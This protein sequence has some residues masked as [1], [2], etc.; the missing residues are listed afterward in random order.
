MAKNDAAP[1]KRVGDYNPE[2]ETGELLDSIANTDVEI[3]G[4]EFDRRNGKNGRY[5]LSIITLTDGRM[6]HTGGAVVAE[7]LAAMFGMSLEQ[8]NAELDA[9]APSPAAPSD[10]FPVLATFTKE[11][12]QNNKAQSYW[13]VT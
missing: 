6:F 11:Q 12:S 7:R 5:T 9:G 1:R 3:S 10:A 13:T 2:T 8:L 4:V